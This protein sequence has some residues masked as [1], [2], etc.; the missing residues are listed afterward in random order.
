MNAWRLYIYIKHLLNTA[1]ES[2]ICTRSN[3]TPGII[4]L[5]LSN[6][7][8]LCKTISSSFPIRF[9]HHQHLNFS[10]LNTPFKPFSLYIY[11]S[12]LFNLDRSLVS[13][14]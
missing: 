6:T 13:F 7:L 3:A 9:H 14:P 1:P 4:F 8:N 11:T 2:S 5:I 10:F 12:I